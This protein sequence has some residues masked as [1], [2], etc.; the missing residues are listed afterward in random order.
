MNCLDVISVG[1]GH[2]DLVTPEAE[3]AIAGAAHIFCADRLAPFVDRPE[4]RHNLLPIPEALTKLDALLEQGCPC[5]VLVSGDAGLYSL[6]PL[7]VRHLGKERIRVIPGISSVQAFCAHLGIPWQDACILS[8]HGR[9]MKPETLCHYVRTNPKTILLLDQVHTPAWIAGILQRGG[10]N[11]VRI[12]T[13]ERLTAPDEVISLYEPGHA[14][15]PLSLALIENDAPHPGLPAAG[16]PDSAF[17]RN[18]TPMTKQEIRVQVL[19]SLAL[20]MDAVVFD[21]GAGTGS[22][23]VECARQCPLG[24]VFAIESDDDACLVLNENLERFRLQNVTVIKGTAPGALHGLQ[25]P[26]HVFI[27]GT[28]GHARE[29][30]DCLTT[31]SSPI[32]LCATAVTME[33]AETFFSLLSNRNDFSAVQIA[34]SRIE[35]V[36]SFHMFRAQNPVFI[37]SA[38]LNA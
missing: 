24:E 16:L 12:T 26:T 30:I 11:Q 32:R 37:F 25:P 28:G 4:K 19:A 17:C 20:P 5:A 21:I 1:P 31:F 34:V 33:S 18:K 22:V 15:D 6:L 14:A 27:G 35:P 36:G 23:T 7:L 9:E 29:I 8:A 3:K 38:T 13:G 2:R 10:L